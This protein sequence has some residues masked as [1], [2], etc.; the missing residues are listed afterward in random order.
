MKLWDFM[1]ISCTSSWVEDLSFTHGWVESSY[2][3]SYLSNLS[4]KEIDELPGKG[5]IRRTTQKDYFSFVYYQILCDP[6]QCFL[7]VPIFCYFVWVVAPFQSLQDMTHFMT[8]ILVYLTVYHSAWYVSTVIQLS[9]AYVLA[10][11]APLCTKEHWNTS[12]I[13]T[14]TK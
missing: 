9:S 10:V 3:I 1:M 11:W 13:Y 4:H 5:S 7:T 6:E 8:V 14:N 12:I 2:N